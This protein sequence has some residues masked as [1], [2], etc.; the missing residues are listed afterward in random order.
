MRLRRVDGKARK[1]WNKQNN[2]KKNI[3]H[4]DIYIYS[5]IHINHKTV[6]HI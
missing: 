6:G 1:T 4:A 3:I 5:Y 2:M